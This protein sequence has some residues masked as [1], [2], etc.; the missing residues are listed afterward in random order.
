MGCRHGLF[1]PG[2]PLLVA[3]TRRRAD[4]ALETIYPSDEELSR[5]EWERPTEG[6]A[7]TA[8]SA[9]SRPCPARGSAG[10]S[11]I[12]TFFPSDVVVLLQHDAIERRGM[13]EI[14]V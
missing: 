2:H 4:E 6:P 8:T 13:K 9:A 10:S 11:Q 7:S 12:R 1:G 5:E 14:A 3:A